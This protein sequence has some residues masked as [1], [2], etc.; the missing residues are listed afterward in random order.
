[1]DMVRSHSRMVI[2]SKVTSPRVN[3][4]DMGY[5]NL[6]PIPMKASS[7]MVSTMGRGNTLG[8]LVVITREG[9]RMDRRVDM[10]YM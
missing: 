6:Q 2:P 7:V 10:E 3:S 8:V 5:L 1:M 9:M 4:K